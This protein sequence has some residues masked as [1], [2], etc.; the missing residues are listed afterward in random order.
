[1]VAGEVGAYE[2]AWGSFQDVPRARS[3]TSFEDDWAP[4]VP[5]GPESG[6][7]FTGRAGEIQSIVQRYD[8]RV[9]LIRGTAAP[10]VEA[11]ELRTPDGR[12]LPV[13]LRDGVYLAALA[14]PGRLG[15]RATLVATSRG[16]GRY[17]QRLALGSQ[18]VPNRWSS[19][20]TLRRGRVLRVLW[21]GGFEPF[22]GVEVRRSARTLGVTILE[23][24][25]PS[26]GPEGL[27]IGI[28]AIAISKCAD[29]VLDAPIGHRVVTTG[30]NGN[31]P[32]RATPIDRL[33]FVAGRRPRCPRVRP[34]ERLLG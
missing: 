24:F 31:R 14:S 3:T 10:E 6:V 28:P 7:C 23:R 32:R 18:D 9:A 4:G 12:R 22:A 17:V 20:G 2:S 1:V 11:I 13:T 26:F 33:F 8:D 25:P 5:A 19:Y 21:T 29:V 27:P 34:G 15:E 16:G 30:R